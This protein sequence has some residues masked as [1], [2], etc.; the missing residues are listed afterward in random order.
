MLIY[1]HIKASLAVSISFI[2]HLLIGLLGNKPGVMMFSLCMGANTQVSQS[3]MNC[4]QAL[5]VTPH[6]RLCRG[7]CE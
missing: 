4:C 3:K 6:L 5:T 1:P 7:L 2:I